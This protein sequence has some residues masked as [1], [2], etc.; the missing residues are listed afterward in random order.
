MKYRYIIF[1][2]L[3]VLSSVDASAQRRKMQQQ[4]VEP[5][6]AQVVKDY[7]DSLT[8]LRRQLDSLH[9]VN[10]QLKTEVSDGQ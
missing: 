4:V 10:A 1:L 8:M 9:Q 7:I 5:D 3:V 2:V 6:T